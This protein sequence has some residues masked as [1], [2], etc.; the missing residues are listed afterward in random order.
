MRWLDKDEG[1]VMPTGHRTITVPSPFYD[2]SEPIEIDEKLAPLIQ[3]LW[4][5]DIQT[6]QSCQEYYPG[7]C[8][9]EFPGTYEV[10]EFLD[11][12]QRNYKIDVETQDEGKDDRRSIV[13]RLLVLF[14]LADVD[15]LVNAWK[16][17]KEKG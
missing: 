9:I 3:L 12:A 6:C 11:V 15:M 4:A 7:L 13:V 17:R 10:M 5:A 16:R 8:C 2:G 14:P 1:Q